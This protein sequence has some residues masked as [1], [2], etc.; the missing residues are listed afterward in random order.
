M[1]WKFLQESYVAVENNEPLGLISLVPDGSTKTRWKINRLVLAANAYDIGKQLIDYVVNKYGGDG[2]EIFLTV[3]DE[4]APDAIALFKKECFF[5]QYSKL[6]IWELEG[7]V[8]AGEAPDLLREAVPADAE[9]LF[10]LDTSAI[11]P[12]LRASFT[13]K[14]E[15]F[16]FDLPKKLADT[17]KGYKACRY[18]LDNPE[19]NTIEGLLSIL[20]ADRKHYWIDITLSLA[21]K[22]YYET[23]LSHAIRKIKSSIPDARMYIGTKDYHQVSGYMT[24]VLTEHKFRQCGSFQILVKDYWKPAKEYQENKVQSMIF[25]DITS[26]ACNITRF[27][28]ES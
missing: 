7:T 12:H 10:E 25:S 18:V 3:I 11:V 1:Q 4:N 13:K 20:T 5:R 26:P 24:E 27:I 16:R 22:Q 15:D 28:S 6:N 17:F 19:N 14:A 8:S 2:V 21:Y 9:K 23:L